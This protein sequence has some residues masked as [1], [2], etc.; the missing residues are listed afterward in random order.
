MSDR[1]VVEFKCDLCGATMVALPGK[2]PPKKW[3]RPTLNGKVYDVC[4][5]CAGTIWDLVRIRKNAR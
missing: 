5:Y 4:V 3:F 2:V 1:T